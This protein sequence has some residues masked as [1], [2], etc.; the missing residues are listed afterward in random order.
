VALHAD[1]ITEDRTARERRVGVGGNYRHRTIELPQKRDERVD[2]GRLPGSRSS[3]EADD[4]GLRAI[5]QVGFDRPDGGIA[6]LDEADRAGE[7]ADVPRAEPR[8]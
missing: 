2:Q 7:G 3:R 4:V 6:L 5:L 8:G 1:A